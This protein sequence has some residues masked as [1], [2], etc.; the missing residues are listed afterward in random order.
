VITEEDYNLIDPITM[1]QL[2]HMRHQEFLD[3]AARDRRAFAIESRPSIS[4]LVRRFA[5]PVLNVVR[6]SMPQETRATAPILADPCL[7]PCP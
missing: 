3:E 4:T 2:A 5:A 1:N 6:S 7:E